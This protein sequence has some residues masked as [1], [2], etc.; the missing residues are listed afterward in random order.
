MLSAAAADVED[1]F[2]FIGSG[3]I[4]GIDCTGIPLNKVTFYSGFFLPS[5]LCLQLGGLL[6]RKEQKEYAFLFCAFFLV[7]FPQFC[8]FV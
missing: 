5:L 7:F 1:L 6:N 2:D 8:I 4:S 3:G